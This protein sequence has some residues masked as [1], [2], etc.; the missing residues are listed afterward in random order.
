MKP[1]DVLFLS[2]V[3]ACCIVLY[4][5]PRRRTAPREQ[6]VLERWLVVEHATPRDLARG[7]YP[8]PNR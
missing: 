8:D 1:F 3:M 5:I 2:A 6:I 4:A 7:L